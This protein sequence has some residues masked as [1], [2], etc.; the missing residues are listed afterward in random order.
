ML[1]D[2]IRHFNTRYN[3]REAMANCTNRDLDNPFP[4][5]YH[6]TQE[7]LVVW[8]QYD[9]LFPVELAERVVRAIGPSAKL[10]IVQDYGHAPNLEKPKEFN[11]IVLDFLGN[12]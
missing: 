8:G 3:E 4:R 6:L 11:K 9:A 1:K 10:A 5:G 2:L 7:T 12:G